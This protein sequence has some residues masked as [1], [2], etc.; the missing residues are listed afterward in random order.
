MEEE[1]VLLH[2]E[3]QESVVLGDN[4]IMT[5]E[6]A[7]EEVV[8]LVDNGLMV[9]GVAEEEVEEVVEEVEEEVV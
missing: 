7:E 4:G 6:V 8:V 9:T 5:T 1:V 3:V 2:E